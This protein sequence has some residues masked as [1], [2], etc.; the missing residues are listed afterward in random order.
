MVNVNSNNSPIIPAEMLPGD[1]RFGSGPSKIRFSAQAE[2]APGG[3]AYELLGTSHRQA[4]V[5]NLV[6]QIRAG[7]HDLFALP[8]GYEV[9]LGLGGATAFWDIAAFGLVRQRAQNCVM[10]EFSAKCAA[11][12]TV[13]WLQEPEVIA[14]DPG[15]VAVPRA[16][17]GID[18]YAWA[19]NET[20][21]GALSEVIRPPNADDDA[22]VVIDGTS[23]A[24][25]VQVNLA[26]TDVYYFAPQKSFAAEGGLWLAVFSPAALARAEKIAASGRYIPPFFS[27]SA[28]IKNSRAEQ[29]LNTPAITTLGLLAAQI[30][31]M[32]DNGGLQF[33]AGRSAHS[34]AHL[35]SWADAHSYAQPFVDVPHRS[36]V[37][38]TI[39]FHPQIVAA[40]LARIL[41][42][43]GILDVEPY[44][45]LGRN[46]LRVGMFPAVN[47]EDVVALTACVDYV[48]EHLI[49]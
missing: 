4:E 34:A 20:S 17:P 23:A 35:Y 10:G 12:F 22:L 19:H 21:T 26:E 6:G 3:R 14:I 11:S 9:V 37:V 32:N 36:P 43:N 16:Q 7:L 48:L 39:D 28:A 30:D 38:G 45:K 49:N 42:A 24:G 40:D 29:T 1:G 18:V 41:R 15:L 44:R 47:P 8:D 27:L 46:Q 31:W 5:R 25:G 33:A 13:P 2:L